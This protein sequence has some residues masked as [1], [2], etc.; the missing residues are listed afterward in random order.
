MLRPQRAPA[1]VRFAFLVLASGAVATAQSTP[2][3][4]SR[5]RFELGLN[6][7][8]GGV[9]EG[10]N[11]RGR[12]Y[13][14]VEV[15]LG[16]L[17]V[18]HYGINEAGPDYRFGQNTVS[19]G[20][21]DAPGVALIVA[22]KHD[23][24]SGRSLALAQAGYG[25]RID[26]RFVSLPWGLYYNL[27]LFKNAGHGSTSSRTLEAILLLGRTFAGNDLSVLVDWERHEDPYLE[28]EALSRSLLETPHSQLRLWARVEGTDADDAC[29][30]AG[31]HLQAR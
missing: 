29:L 12:I 11:W 18:G 6:A 26:D 25:V 21:A 1:S 28:L 20:L 13:D 3:A 22:A 24:D 15:L 16:Q 5:P 8:Q 27:Q 7:L 10:G 9:F 23:N 2:D 19:L 4:K 31:L 30:G 14:T 17:R